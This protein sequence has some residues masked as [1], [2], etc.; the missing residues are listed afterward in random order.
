MLCVENQQIKNLKGY[1]WDGYEWFKRV[2][3]G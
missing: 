2:E 3:M 1:N